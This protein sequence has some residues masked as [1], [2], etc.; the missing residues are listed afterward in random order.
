MTGIGK[1]FL[2]GAEFHDVSQVHD[3]NH[4]GQLVNHAQVVTDQD[5]GQVE[6]AAQVFDQIQNLCL[7]EHVDGT[8]G[9]VQHHQLGIGGQ[10]TG[11]G[12]ALALAAGKLMGIFVA[13][14]LGDTDHGQQ[15]FD[16]GQTL[17]FAELFVNIQRLRHDV[18][19]Q[20]AGIQ[21]PVRILED[22][23]HV[24]LESVAAALAGFKYIHTFKVHPAVGGFKQVQNG[25][26]QRG[27]AAA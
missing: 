18:L 27:L 3:R 9:L 5:V 7:T 10:G 25:V 14:I 13:G 4:I 1:H 23:L 17:V 11:D 2:C 19:D 16:T 20:P 8:G 26:H 6:L 12:N 15:L 21:R 22:N 24:L